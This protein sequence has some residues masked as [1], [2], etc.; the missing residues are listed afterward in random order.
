MVTKSTHRGKVLRD[1][2]ETEEQSKEQTTREHLTFKAQTHT[3]EL[4]KEPK[5]EWPL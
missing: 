2:A 4:V 1:C 5:M 3:E